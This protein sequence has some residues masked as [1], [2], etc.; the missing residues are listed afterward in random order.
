MGV[1]A[2]VREQLARRAPGLEEKAVRANWRLKNRTRAVG[3]D[4]SDP[5]LRPFLDGLRRD[6]VTIGRFEDLI[7]D[8]ALF[9]AAAAHAQEL[10]E[11]RPQDAGGEAGSKASFLTK[12][13]TREFDADD[14]FVRI[15]LH[16]NVLA[17]A[18]AYMKMH[19]TLRAIELWH[20]HPTPGSAV[21]TQLWHRDADDV[22]NV[23][24]F[25]YFTDVTRAAGPLTYAPRTHPLG[26]RRDVP[27]HDDQW[28]SND[29]QMAK[30]VPESEWKIL[31]G[32]PG[33]VVFAETC[34]YH[35]QLKPESAERIKLVSQYVSGTPYVGRDLK[36][37]GL[38]EASLSDDQYFAVY[39]R[40][41]SS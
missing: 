37:N 38:D 39:D 2:A 1:G 11:Q 29:E 22:M 35:K 12:L 28:R 31:E 41:R 8:Q 23:K 34:G 6:G 15:A 9:D 5:R 26:D 36:L 19:A 7:G 3:E 13:A 10:Y 30:V 21:Q 24:L 25:V 40:P 33:T 4:V 18:N 16:P 27:D 14:P 32:K 20:T 17:V